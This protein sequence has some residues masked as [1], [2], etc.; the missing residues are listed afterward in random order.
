MTDLQAI[1]AIALFRSGF[2]TVDI[3][4]LLGIPEPSIVRVLAA[5][6]DI[7]AGRAP[8]AVVVH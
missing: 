7:A 3:A 6:R 8:D 2:D 1:A 4:A 5:S